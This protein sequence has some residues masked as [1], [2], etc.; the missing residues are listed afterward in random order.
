MIWLNGNIRDAAG[1]FSAQDRGLLLGEA[2]FETL[3]V[4]DGVPQ[5][6]DAHLAR[7]TRACTAFGLVMPYDT[8][9]LKNGVLSLFDA[10]AIKPKADRPGARHVLRL[11]VTGGDGGRGLVPQNTGAPNWLMQISDAAAP[12]AYLRL[13]ESDIA[14]LAG[15]ATA[16]HKTTAY[17]DHILARRAALNAGADEALMFNQ[18][19]RLAGAAAATIF[20]QT[21]KQLITPPVSEGALAGIIR[22]ALLQLGEAGGLNIAEGLI[23]RDLLAKADALYLSN[24]VHGV[25]PAQLEAGHATGPGAAQKKQGHALCEALPQFDRF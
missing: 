9:A 15:G 21:G 4:V 3:L 1:A 20:V 18:H 5:F 12:P 2:V 11:T 7:L 17:L 19:G 23:G 24:S 22:A 8:A 16:G 25:V 10:H 13:H 14:V 6:W